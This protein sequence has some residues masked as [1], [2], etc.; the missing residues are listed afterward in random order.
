MLTISGSV[1][2]IIILLEVFSSISQIFK[3]DD[4]P[5][6]MILK[7]KS[8]TEC[9]NGGK[10]KNYEYVRNYDWF[11]KDNFNILAYEKSGKIVFLKDLQGGEGNN[12]S[13][14]PFIEKNK[15]LEGQVDNA[16]T[17]D[18][19]V[20][21]FLQK[22]LQF[23]VVN[24]KSYQESKTKALAKYP[25]LEGPNAEYKR[26]KYGVSNLYESLPT[27]SATYINHDKV[28]KTEFNDIADCAKKVSVGS[29][30]VYGQ[31][32][33]L[34]KTPNQLVI[35]SIADE[36]SCVND[37]L[38]LVQKNGGVSSGYYKLNSRSTYQIDEEMRIGYFN[39]KGEFVREKTI[40]QD[41]SY[42]K[43]ENVQYLGGLF[44]EDK[45]NSFYIKKVGFDTSFKDSQTLKLLFNEKQEPVD[46]YLKSCKNYQGKNIFEAFKN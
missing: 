35:T 4:Q 24:D 10:I 12:D 3:Y 13:L 1:T 9:N 19:P 33:G 32:K 14:K 17:A 38:I 36:F 34:L 11:D 28:S 15:F 27:I 21:E 41:F 20:L 29:V 16:I 45:E 30:F 39:L 22:D 43:K 42:Y 37:G 23:T 2:A 18:F 8:S 6:A 31:A 26:E 44:N 40:D 5:L 25:D 46:D 7:E